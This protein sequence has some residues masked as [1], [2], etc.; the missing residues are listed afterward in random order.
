MLRDTVKGLLAIRS[1][2]KHSDG[3]VYIA[4]CRSALRYVE[5]R[6]GIAMIEYVDVTARVDTLPEQNMEVLSLADMD[7]YK[8]WYDTLSLIVSII[9]TENEY[10][11]DS[12]QMG[13]LFTHVISVEYWNNVKNKYNGDLGEFVMEN[14]LAPYMYMNNSICVYGDKGD[15]QSIDISKPIDQW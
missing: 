1:L 12:S 10:S 13:V 3:S 6:K 4:L 14:Y 2:D 5:L 7:E 11:F 9:V 15:I 8:L